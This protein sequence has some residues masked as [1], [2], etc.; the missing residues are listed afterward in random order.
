MKF[1]CTWS[2]H[3]DEWVPL[4]KKWISMSPEERANAGD[5]VKMIGRWHD[6]AGRTGV[7]I[8]ESNDLAA[9]QR[10]IGRWNPYM[11]IALTPVVNDEETAAIARQIV[12]DNKF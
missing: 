1:M 7:V 6:M 4:L 11:D 5:G 2:I 10:Y 9:V 8:F 3:E 12:A